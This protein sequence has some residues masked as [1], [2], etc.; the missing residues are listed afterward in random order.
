MMVALP[1]ISKFGPEVLVHCEFHQ[2][3]SCASNS[4]SLV[5]SIVLQSK[6]KLN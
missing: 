5:F 2:G 3:S 6:R 1:V 4:E